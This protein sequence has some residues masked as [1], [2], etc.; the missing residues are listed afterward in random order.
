MEASHD[1]L[2]TGMMSSLLHLKKNFYFIE[3]WLIYNVVFLS[4]VWHGDS[5]IQMYT[6]FLIFFSTTVYCG[7]L[8]V[9]PCAVAWGLVVYP[10][11][12]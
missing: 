7:I 12:I 2:G 9:V 3:V 11:Y 8:T 6:F 10:A 1:P 5:F 4:A